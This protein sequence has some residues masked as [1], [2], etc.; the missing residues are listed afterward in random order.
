MIV[1]VPCFAGFTFI[2]YLMF[3]PYLYT[4]HTFSYALKSVLFFSF[5]QLDTRDLMTANSFVAVAWTLS[6]YF[7]L[8]FIFLSLLTALFLQAYDSA[9]REGYPEDRPSKFDYT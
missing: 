6:F 1:L 8:S 7:F 2:A 4:Y 9:I 3:G 5:G